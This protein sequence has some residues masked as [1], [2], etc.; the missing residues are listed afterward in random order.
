MRHVWL[1]FF[2]A[3]GLLAMGGTAI[4]AP[5]P[6]RDQIQT[7]IPYV[8]LLEADSGTVLF[9]KAADQLIAHAS[10]AK[11]M[12]AETVFDQIALGNLTLDD[13]FVVSENAWALWSGIFMLR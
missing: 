9:E 4:A 8:M 13:E 6:G 12:T 3:M 7:S 11:L 10:L 2:A 5:A 1:N